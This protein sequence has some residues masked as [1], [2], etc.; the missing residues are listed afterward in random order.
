MMDAAHIA[1]EDLA[2]HAMQ[3]LS[4][5]EESAVGLHLESC[6]MCRVEFAKLTGDLALV[7]QAV[8]EHALPAG[9]RERFM[10]RIGAPAASQTAK[11]KVFGIGRRRPRWP[12]T[13]AL[14]LAAAALVLIAV[15]LG[16]EVVRLRAKLE[17]ASALTAS[18]RQSN[19][20]AQKVLEVLTAP[21]AQRA[22]LTAAMSKPAP[23]GR[24]VY[25][26]SRGTLI[27]QA[28]NLNALPGNKTYEL[29]LIPANGSPPIP[30]G[31][32]KPDLAGNAAVVLPPI[33]AGVPAKAFGVT[34]EK[35]S[36]SETP[37]LPIVLSGGATSTGE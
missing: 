29:W 37:T 1:Q 31:L 24:A 22:L 4:A 18:L 23:S 26:A 14:P 20:R 6:P 25:L 12:R 30:A 28:S 27:F 5:E 32:F 3:A 34:I 19:A 9:A 36:G 21:S 17:Q 16:V 15:S 2:L 35:A 8:Q 33:P 10:Q 13:W 7:G 11:T